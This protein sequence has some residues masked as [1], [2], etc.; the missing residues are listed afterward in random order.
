MIEAAALDALL[1]ADPVATVQAAIAARLKALL[2]GIAV[3]LHPGKVDLSE[4]VAKS[5]VAAPG[6]G[7]GW[8]RIRPAPMGRAFRILR[9]QSHV[10]IK[11]DTRSEETKT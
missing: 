6:I 8:S 5:V 7:L 10:T 3:V 9:R 4:I 1:A 11:L 2:P